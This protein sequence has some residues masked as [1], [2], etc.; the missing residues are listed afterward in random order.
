MKKAI[1]ASVIAMAMGAMGSA[2]AAGNNSDAGTIDLNFHGTVSSKTCALTPVVNGKT[3]V[4]NVQ[5][6]QTNKN[7]LGADIE[8]VFKPTAESAADCAGVTTDF[9]MQ[10]DGVGGSAFEA[11]GLKASG[12]AATDAYVLVKATNAKA[13]NGAQVD[14]NGYQY[15]FA[16]ESVADGLKYTM[17]LQGGTVV[18]DMTAAATVKHWYK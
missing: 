14:K 1:I 18:G 2:Y 5:L 3:G 15:E 11:K 6:G 10:W 7:T 4:M 8:V 17:N 16:K 9:V 13:N 12:G